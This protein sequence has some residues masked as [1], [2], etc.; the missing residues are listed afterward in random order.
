[1][2]DQFS[3][4]SIIEQGDS[5][6]QREERLRELARVREEF[7]AAHPYDLATARVGSPRAGG[8]VVVQTER[9]LGARTVPLPQ[10]SL[11][12]STPDPRLTDALLRGGTRYATINEYSTGTG[13]PAGYITEYLLPHLEEG[14]LTLEVAAGQLFVHTAPNGRPRTD[15]V[16]VEA[17]LWE[18]LRRRAGVG[19]AAETWACIRGLQR[20]GWQVESNRSRVMT[21]VQTSVT[22]RVVES[23]DVGLDLG[24]LV[25]P[26]LIEP[27]TSVIGSPF[28]PLEVLD[29]A[30]VLVVAI[31]C[32]AGSLDSYSTAVRLAQASS[33]QQ[34]RMHVLMLEAP[35]YPA[36]LISPTDA[37][38]LPRAVT[39]ILPT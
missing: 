31:C 19:A 10:Q 29:S 32:P 11:T 25:V 37:G 27:S 4:T 24:D 15:G 18:V 6:A 28:G 5:S 34:M 3:S 39:R 36:T 26:V 23:I 20:A 12:L 2:E 21:A 8:D 13:I 22:D 7:N 16:R 1:M 38:V 14:T 33:A 35:R 30:G 9:T 17:N